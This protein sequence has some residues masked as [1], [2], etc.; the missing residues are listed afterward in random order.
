MIAARGPETAFEWRRGVKW[1][2]RFEADA[3]AVVSSRTLQIDGRT[4]AALRVSE[5]AIHTVTNQ[6]ALASAHIDR[7][8]ALVNLG[9]TA[10]YTAAVD[11]AFAAI[12]QLS[13]PYPHGHLHALAAL[14]ARQQG[15]PER[16]VTHLVHAARALGSVT[17]TDQDLAWG[18]HDL[19]MAHSYLGFHGHA[20]SA[21]ERARDIGTKAQLSPELFA[22]PS[23]RLRMALSLDHHGDSDGCLRVLRDL[24]TEL[25]QYATTALRP[26]GRAAFGYALA[27]QAALDE[28]PNTNPRPLLEAGV[29]GQRA[30]DM[31]SLGD[32][33]LLIA[34]GK[35]T[36][37]LTRLDTVSVSP[38]TFGP[39]EPARLRSL[40][41]AAAGD[42]AAAHGA[43]RYAFRLVAQRADRLRDM[44][45]EGIAA[46]LDHEDLR[47]SV[48]R[49]GAE[50][51]TDPL[52]GL[53]DRRHLERHLAT[54]AS[55]GEHAMIGILDI[56]GLAAVNEVHGRLSGDLVLQRVAGVLAR[57]MRRGDFVARYGSD[58]FV[59]VLPR[60]SSAQAAEVA[61]RITEA[62]GDEDWAALLPGTHIGVTVTWSDARRRPGTAAS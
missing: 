29:E 58:E 25:G 39:A 54:M 18:W 52:T 24:S 27:R 6:Y 5:R 44:F 13:E 51:W 34:A 10:Q 60:A 15:A 9:R 4:A 45:L 23:I 50:A 8:C 49:Q 40:A 26:S 59:V 62:I 38:D 43:D 46:R 11:E 19:A 55:R 16:G 7:V 56:D 1:R 12:R 30:R 33:C 37:A 20:L 57:V 17:E 48:A 35:A 42:H 32:V 41:F 53:P 3:D 22:V 61:H 31:R 28:P 14:A 36:D 47:R 2:D 21:I